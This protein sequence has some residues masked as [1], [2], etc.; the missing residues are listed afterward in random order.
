MEKVVPKLTD[1]RHRVISV[2]KV[3]F[4]VFVH[5]LFNYELN[6]VITGSDCLDVIL[7]ILILENS[8]HIVE[9]DDRVEIDEHGKA[10]YEQT[11]D[12]SVFNSIWLDDAAILEEEESVISTLL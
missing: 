8:P 4:K 5:L 6:C 12:L 2:I 10:R 1:F 9:V 7:D 3:F 11:Y